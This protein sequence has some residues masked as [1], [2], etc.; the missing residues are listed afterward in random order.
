MPLTSPL[1]MLTP[2]DALERFSLTPFQ[3]GD[4]GNHTKGVRHAKR[5][6]LAQIV[7]K[8]F[9]RLSF[10]VDHLCVVRP[11]TQPLTRMHFVQTLEGD[12]H[13]CSCGRNEAC[14]VHIVPQLECCEDLMPAIQHFDRE[15]ARCWF[16]CRLPVHKHT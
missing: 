4:S 13:K 8:V 12:L 3:P 7:H 15:R 1:S 5:T 2:C 6:G 14:P 16:R 11:Q 10:V 9:S